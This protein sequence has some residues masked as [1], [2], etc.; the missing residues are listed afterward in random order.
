MN[1]LRRALPLVLVALPAA[2]A[3]DS[4]FAHDAAA[5]LV[6][7]HQGEAT[8]EGARIIDLT[9]AADPADPT[10]RTRA[11]LV[12]PAAEVPSGSAPG[13]LWGHW[14]GEPE[15]TNRTQFLPEAVTWARRGAVSVLTEAMWA[16]PG[17]YRARQLDEDFSRGVKQV[18]AFRRTM[19]LLFAQAGVNPA[20]TAFVAHD[21][22]AMYGSI[23]LAED[24]RIQHAVFIAAAPTLEDWAFYT[25]QPADREAYL[26]QNRPL[27]LPEHLARLTGID[28]LLQ[29]AEEDFYVPSPRRDLFIESVPAG[30]AVK[31]YA[32]AGHEMT[33]PPAIL[34]DRTAWLSTA[35][36]VD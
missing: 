1:L 35:L 14:L 26:A 21:Y 5:D 31:I 16:E 23:A 9:F 36:A 12:L 4:P 24:R 18:V 28:L 30:A 3:Q 25:Q 22:S 8:R 6:I 32:G 29:W 34:A 2:M 17:W 10:V 15:T 33:T 19:D 7:E 11:Y 27:H 13:I 20:R